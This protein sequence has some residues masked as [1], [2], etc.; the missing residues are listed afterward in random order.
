MSDATEPF[1]TIGEVA[2]ILY[3]CGRG[4]D[5]IIDGHTGFH[6]VIYPSKG[7]FH[8][9]GNN[10]DEALRH[11]YTKYKRGDKP[12]AEYGVRQHENIG[13][14]IRKSMYGDPDAWLSSRI[15]SWEEQP[16]AQDQPDD[17]ELMRLGRA[18]LREVMDGCG[19]DIYGGSP[20]PWVRAMNYAWEEGFL[21]GYTAQ[22]QP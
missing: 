16:P 18:K 2:R 20:E 5:I 10:T 17:D 6:A 3:E 13:E 11:A 21:E 4:V 19:W 9:H 7:M 12:D 15:K 14:A 1:D 8:G 22:A